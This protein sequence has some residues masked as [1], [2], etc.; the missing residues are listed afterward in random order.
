MQQHLIFDYSVINALSK[1]LFLFE[2]KKSNFTWWIAEMT[3]DLKDD[4]YW[5]NCR[6]FCIS[7]QRLLLS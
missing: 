3:S 6:P 4:T 1:L 7:C 2:R 5:I